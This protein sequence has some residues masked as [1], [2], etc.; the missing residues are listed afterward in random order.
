[1]TDNART[2]IQGYEVGPSH[3]DSE[4]LKFWQNTAKEGQTDAVIRATTLNIIFVSTSEND[5]QQAVQL[6]AGI[7][8]H[9]PARMILVHIDEQ[10]G[11]DK[12]KAHISAYCQPPQQSGKQICC[13]QI[14]LSTGK[15]GTA[16]LN[17]AILP[18]LLPDLP[19]FICCPPA[20]LLDSD[21]F[22]DLVHLADRV[23]LDTQSSFA[24]MF[25]LLKTTKHITHLDNETHLSD[26]AWSKLTKWREAIAQLFDSQNETNRLEN[27]NA[28]EIT[29]NETPTSF[30]GY[31][32][33]FW[34]ATRL[35]WN[36]DRIDK[37]GLTIQL[38]GKDS[39]IITANLK[40]INSK[41]NAGALQR[42]ELL[43]KASYERSTFNCRIQDN[44]IMS[45]IAVDGQTTQNI[46]YEI[47]DEGR[48][49]LVCDELD[50][51]HED[52]I[53]LQSINAISNII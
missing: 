41:T 31:L 24:N 3:I 11:D 28:V 51:L 22:K 18:L 39:Q 47:L 38:K 48:A 8:E 15:K 34:L 17:G 53:Y 25:E 46:K 23:I 26:L 36:I 45:A 1:M 44:Y 21:N 14:S 49:K 32:I 37:S 20:E 40:S 5:Y 16:H 27:I 43:S 29:T 52:E 42:V 9:H 2:Y 10:L 33:L 50:F 4:L 30:M 13:E 35:G 6:V 7:T 19:V 12:I